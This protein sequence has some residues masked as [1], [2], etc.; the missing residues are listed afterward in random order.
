MSRIAVIGA[1][2]AVG[3]ELLILLTRPGMPPARIVPVASARSS[4]T[5]IAGQLGL[6]ADIE[7]VMALDDLDFSTVDVAFYAAGAEISRRTAEKAAGAGC[8]VID[9]SSAFRLRDDVPLVVPQVNPEAL[10]HRPAA[11]LIANPNCSTVQLVRALNPLRAIAGLRRVILA[12]YQAGSGGG[13]RGLAELA[14]D[15]R[16]VLDRGP[17][18]EPGRFGPPLAF[19]LIPQIGDFG[20]DSTTHEERKLHNEP[21]KIM[22]LPGLSVSATAV[23]VPIF[24]CHAEAAWV[25]F[26]RPV[27]TADAEAVLAASPGLKLYR[28]RDD[29]PYPSPRQVERSGQDRRLVHVGR[30][31]ADVDE[32]NALWLWIVADN[33]WVGAALNAV[34]ILSTARGFGWLSL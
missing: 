19:D 12:T 10:G 14:G 16:R 27:T 18:P 32:P 28:A 23:R 29:Q 17:R 33:L 4:G 24:H 2:G 30:V 26:D 9:N 7:P 1:T 21:A 5:D 20:D 13:M 25:E 3:R 11:N 8:L 22:G 31:R 6:D 34:D 15:S